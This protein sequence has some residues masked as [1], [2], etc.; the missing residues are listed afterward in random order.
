MKEALIWIG[1]GIALCLYLPLMIGIL[2]GQ[3]IQSF[4]TWILWL[5]LDAIAL[6]SVIQQ[7]GNYL[8]L[9]C[10]CIGA[11][12]ILFSLL[13]MKLFRWT[14]FETFVL[15]LVI[16]CLILWWMIGTKMATIASTIA[17]VIAGAPQF[18]DLWI[19]PDRK[20]GLIYL[21]YAV[22]NGL[23][24]LGAKSWAIQEWFY[25]GMCTLLC[26]GLAMAALRKKPVHV[27]NVAIT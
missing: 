14:T 1:S 22:A 25:P 16:I 18:K 5:A 23:S 19:K 3:I 26:S 24:A 6:I 27:H 10:F 20:T 9:V 13:Y 12:I 4:A 8:I 17:V 7:Q 11:I 15:I 2:R 21:G